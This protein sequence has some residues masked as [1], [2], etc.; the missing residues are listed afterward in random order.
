MGRG[1]NGAGSNG[2]FRG[3]FC[4]PGRG[5]EG[6]WSRLTTPWSAHGATWN[7]VAVQ[8]RSVDPCRK[9]GHR[10]PGKGTE[11]GC[12]LRASLW[13]YQLTVP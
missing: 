8:S 10:I 9:T 2:L 4:L 6:C 7:A 11:R 1:V 5:P 12:L 13:T 3:V